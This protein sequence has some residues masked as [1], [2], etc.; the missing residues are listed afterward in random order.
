MYV[1]SLYNYLYKQDRL[2]A[3]DE[4]KALNARQL[5]IDPDSLLDILEEQVCTL[6]LC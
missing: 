6:R 3:L 4:L 2:E 5:E 1:C